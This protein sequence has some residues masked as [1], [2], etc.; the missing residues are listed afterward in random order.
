MLRDESDEIVRCTLEDLAA[1]KAERIDTLHQRINE[2]CLDILRV[3]H[4]EFEGRDLTYPQKKE[5]A[6]RVHLLLD[7]QGLRPACL[8]CSEPAI[9]RANSR[10]DCGSFLFDHYVP[11]SD[12]T[13]KKRRTNHG[14]YMEFP[15]I[16]ALVNTPRRGRNNSTYSQR[17]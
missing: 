8:E 17:A 14:C 16:T 6:Y 4:E 3:L 13:T 15:L 12:D 2:M 1:M 5:I 9:L 7:E 10:L 11:D